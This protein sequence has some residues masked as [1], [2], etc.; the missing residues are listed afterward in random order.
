MIRLRLRACQVQM[1]RLHLWQ[2]EK[3]NRAAASAQRGAAR[4]PSPDLDARAA[5]RLLLMLR[6]VALSS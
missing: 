1:L 6:E 5:Q 2:F 3:L 4:R